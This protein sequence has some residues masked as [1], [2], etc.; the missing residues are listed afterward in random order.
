MLILTYFFCDPLV[1]KIIPQEH[2]FYLFIILTPGY[3]T[4]LSE[5]P[6]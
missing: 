1:H 6:Q 3:R 4:E 2:I 5:A